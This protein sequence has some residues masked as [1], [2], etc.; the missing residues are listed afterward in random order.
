[1]PR[2]TRNKKGG[3]NMAK[4]EKAMKQQQ[5]GEMNVDNDMTELKNGLNVDSTSMQKRDMEGGE[6]QGLEMQGGEMQGGEMQ[7]G[8]MQKRDMEGVEMQGLELGGVEKDNNNKELTG[9]ENLNMTVNE[10][11]NEHNSPGLLNSGFSMIKNAVRGFTGG[12]RRKVGGATPLQTK[13]F[14]SLKARSQKLNEHMREIQGLQKHLN[15]KTNSLSTE[16]SGLQNL[17][18]QYNKMSGGRKTRK[19]HHKRKSHHRRKR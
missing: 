16:V 17:F 9:G 7:G 19:S 5:G 10:L 1:M 2:K 14:T 11:E 6:M 18:N 12:S 8:E 15:G 4:L 3:N 13:L